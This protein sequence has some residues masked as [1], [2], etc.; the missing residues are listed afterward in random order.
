[1]CLAVPDDEWQ[2]CAAQ[3]YHQI[4]GAFLV[5][6]PQKHRDPGFVFGIGVSRQVKKVCIDFEWLWRA[7]Q[8][9]LSSAV[10]DQCGSGECVIESVQHEHASRLSGARSAPNRKRTPGS[11]K[12]CASLSFRRRPPRQKYTSTKFKKSCRL[13]VQPFG[14]SNAPYHALAVPTAFG[15]RKFISEI[16]GKG[17]C[18]SDPPILPAASREWWPPRKVAANWPRSNDGTL[19]ASRLG[20]HEDNLELFLDDDLIVDAG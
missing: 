1:M 8:Q 6:G 13:Q 7:F 4:R 16:N 3:R 14:L 18:P 20:A 9:A 12:L 5:L 15:D 2:S 11:T 10:R 19:H 17:I